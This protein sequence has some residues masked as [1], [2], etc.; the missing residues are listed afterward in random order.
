LNW[1]DA[2]QSTCSA[3]NVGS[4]EGKLGIFVGLVS[5]KSSILLAGDGVGTDFNLIAQ[6]NTVTGTAIG[7]IQFKKLVLIV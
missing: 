5:K 1:K 3:S 6:I 4:E 7:R 2:K